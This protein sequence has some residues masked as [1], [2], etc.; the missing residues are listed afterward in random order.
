MLDIG[1]KAPDFSAPDQHGN[2]HSLSD[3]A[4]RWVLLYFYPKD[5]TP[6]CTK[7]AKAFRDTFQHYL[8]Q[9]INVVGISPDSVT[10]HKRFAAK[11]HLPFSLLSDP[12]RKIIKAYG[13]LGVFN[14]VKRISYLINDQSIVAKTYPKVTPDQH[15]NEILQDFTNLTCP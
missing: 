14:R 1:E 3:Y 10:R 6:G 12:S 15:A 9:N 7:E 5:D 2:M 4:G 11:Y 13:A 8:D